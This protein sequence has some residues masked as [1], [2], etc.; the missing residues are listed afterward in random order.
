MLVTPRQAS[1][2]GGLPCRRAGLTCLPAGL[3][4]AAR[5]SLCASR[6]C[7]RRGRGA[8]VTAARCLAAC[9]RGPASLPQSAP[10]LV[11]G[12][13][14]RDTDL[15]AGAV[16]ELAAVLRVDNPAVEVRAAR[17]DG[18]GLDDPSDLRAVLVDA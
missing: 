7:A 10:A 1:P 3:T 18:G 17:I 2:G 9:R 14:G 4:A 12:V 8:A 15:S 11:L 16:G 6:R 13:P 5:R